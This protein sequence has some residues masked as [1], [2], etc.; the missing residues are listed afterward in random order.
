MPEALGLM[1]WTSELMRTTGMNSA[2]SHIHTGFGDTIFAH[3]PLG[4]RGKTGRST[5][6]EL[7]LHHCTYTLESNREAHE[8]HTYRTIRRFRPEK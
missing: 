8:K 5:L 1:D 4:K 2:P 7:E 3:H 6:P